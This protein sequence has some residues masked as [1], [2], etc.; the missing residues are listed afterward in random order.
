MSQ[1]V[2]TDRA[3]VTEQ[4][5]PSLPMEEKPD[6]DRRPAAPERG[7]VPGA[8]ES[9]REWFAQRFWLEPPLE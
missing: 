3:D 8:I 9:L 7:R 5:H 2:S 6:A 4:A 1:T